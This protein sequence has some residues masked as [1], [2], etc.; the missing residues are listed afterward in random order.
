MANLRSK[1]GVDVNFLFPD[2]TAIDS[3]V[4]LISATSTGNL[5]HVDKTFMFNLETFPYLFNSKSMHF[6]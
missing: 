4:L 1:I 2:L 3:I 6:R 5:F